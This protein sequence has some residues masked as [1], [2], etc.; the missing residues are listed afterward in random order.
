MENE[1]QK[2]L[3]PNSIFSS[4]WNV[5]RK[6]S[7]S[8]ALSGDFIG[9]EFLL[10]CAEQASIDDSGDSDTKFEFEFKNF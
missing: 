3:S 9:R 10:E 8:L 6:V 7:Q 5:L 4:N 2:L 1:R